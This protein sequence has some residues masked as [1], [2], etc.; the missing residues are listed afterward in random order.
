M[1]QRLDAVVLGVGS[2]GT[3]GGLAA[4]FK[5]HAPH[6][7]LVLADPQGSILAEYIATGKMTQKGSWLVE[8]IGEDFIPTIC[9][10]SLTKRAYSIPDAESFSVARELLQKEAILAGSSTGTLLAAALRFCREQKTPKRVVTFACDTGARYLSKLY[11]DFWMEDQGFIERET[12]R[13]S[14]RPDRPSARRARDDHGRSERRADHG[15]Q[16]PAQRRLL[17]AAGDGRRQA[18]RRHHRGRHPALLVR[19]SRALQR[20]GAQRHDRD[21]PARRQ[22]AVDQQSGR[23]ARSAR[24]RGRDGR[25]QVPRPDHALGRSELSAPAGYDPHVIQAVTSSFATR[26]IHGGQSP[27]PLDRRGDAADLRDLDVRAVEPRRAQGLRLLAHRQSDAR[28]VGALHR[29]SRKRHARLR[30]RLGHGGDQH[31]ARADRCRQPHRRDGRSVR[32]HVPRVRA[33]AP[34]LGEPRRHA[35][36]ISTQHASAGEGR[37]AE[38]AA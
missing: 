7:E 1:S 31:A 11:N 28:R 30:V 6:V 16:S 36:S 26:C 38:D 3:I 18:H 24:V 14:A 12:L 35:S 17:A 33:R 5:K 9:D 15:A 25:R 2:S 32:R 21:V 20:A 13:R 34:A 8:G 19:P 22:D 29:R 37:A 27:D 10:F 23:D 4:F